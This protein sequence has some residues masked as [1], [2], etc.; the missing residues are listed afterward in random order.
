MTALMRDDRLQAEVLWIAVP[1]ERFGVQDQ[2]VCISAGAQAELGAA[3]L[4]V[5]VTILDAAPKPKRT[6]D[7]CNS[8]SSA[9]GF[10]FLDGS[11]IAPSHVDSITD[12]PRARKVVAAEDA[13]GRGAGVCLE[14]VSLARPRYWGPALRRQWSLPALSARGA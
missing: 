4:A 1:L 13:T 8:L 7:A 10:V 5:N 9:G 14:A 6:S 11:W 12:R 2:Q 3:R